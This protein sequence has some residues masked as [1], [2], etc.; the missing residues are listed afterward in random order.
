MVGQHGKRILIGSDISGQVVLEAIQRST[1]AAIHYKVASIYD[2]GDKDAAPLIICCE[3]L[4]HLEFPEKALDIL[5]RIADPY[6]IASI[7]QEPLWRILN[8][9]R[10]NYL[11]SLGNTPGH[12]QRWS[13]KGFLRFLESR[14]EILG[15]KTPLPWVMA[16]CRTKVSIYHHQDIRL[17]Q[18]AED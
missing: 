2:L 18:A 7:P 6:L 5:A 10:G 15:V 9:L 8:I 3:V 14:F 11:G 13:K 17:H 16:L 1:S 12:L 4:E